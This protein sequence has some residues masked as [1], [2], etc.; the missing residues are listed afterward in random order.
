MRMY[1]LAHLAHAECIEDEVWYKFDPFL[2]YF[3]EMKV[4]L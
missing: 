4:G 3:P 2:A 1:L